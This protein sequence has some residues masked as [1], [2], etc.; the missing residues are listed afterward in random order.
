MSKLINKLCTNWGSWLFCVSNSL[1]MLIWMD[2]HVSVI[3]LWSQ[4]IKDKIEEF[5]INS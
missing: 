3:L 5:S 1:V 4:Y 2:V